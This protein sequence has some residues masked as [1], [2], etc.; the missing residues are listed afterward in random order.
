[1]DWR[2]GSAVWALAALA[3]DQGLVL[4]THMAANSYF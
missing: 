4:S 1:M 2:D 3:E